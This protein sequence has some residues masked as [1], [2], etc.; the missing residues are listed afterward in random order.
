MWSE[1]AGH[2]NIMEFISQESGVNSRS[3]FVSAE[4]ETERGLRVLAVRNQK[5]RRDPLY[6]TRATRAFN[7]QQVAKSHPHKEL[8]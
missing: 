6:T 7:L 2:N 8:T 4:V 5:P 3:I 1:E